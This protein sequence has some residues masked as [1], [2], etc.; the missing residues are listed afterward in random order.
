[1]EIERQRGISVS[2]S[3]LALITKKKIN[4]HTPGHKDLQKIPLELNFN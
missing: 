2:T 1:M 4:I 3:V